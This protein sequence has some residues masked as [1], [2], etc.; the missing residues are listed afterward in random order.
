MVAAAVL[1]LAANALRDEPLP[2]FQPLPTLRDGEI[3]TEEAF[4]SLS[5]GQTVFLDARI[6]VAFRAGRVA[7]AMSLSPEEFPSRYAEF[8]P[9][10]KG[11][12][13]I[14]YCSG[15]RCPKAQKLAEILRKKG[16]QNVWVMKEGFYTWKKRGYPTQ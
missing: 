3:T 6:P 16:H 8:E 15:P 14:T 5:R 10:L 7:G 13:L 1:G 2:V 4:Q 12:T 11:Q 9:G